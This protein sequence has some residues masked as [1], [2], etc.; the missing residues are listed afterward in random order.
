[1]TPNVRIG[2][3]P[4]PL[5]GTVYRPGVVLVSRLLSS[6]GTA[7]S[8]WNA[9]RWS[10]R[11]CDKLRARVQ[12]ERAGVDAV[13]L[14]GRAGAVREHVAEVA[15]AGAARHFRANHSV[16]AVLAADCALAVLIWQV[17]R[18]Q[19]AGERPARLAGLLYALNPVAMVRG[20]H[21][22]VACGLEQAEGFNMVAKSAAVW[23]LETLTPAHREWLAALPEGPCEVDDLIEICHGSP[24][25]EDAYLFDELDALRALKVATRPLCLFG[26]THFPITFEQA[27]G[28]VEVARDDA[29]AA[30]PAH[31]PIH[32]V[33]RDRRE[34]LR[35]RPRRAHA[36]EA[37][38]AR[39][40][41]DRRPCTRR[42]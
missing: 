4:V 10:L 35:V 41:E 31:R 38:P 25:D 36:A 27:P 21:D 19:G 42:S 3:V 11:G 39:L 33:W 34:D 22:K 12:V 8:S 20:N 2:L 18:R 7:G 9:R 1:V 17:L 29:S 23:T 6:P 32:A 16:A 14:A 28:T 37:R 40:P 26:H 15:A 24:F 5:F 30:R 13:A